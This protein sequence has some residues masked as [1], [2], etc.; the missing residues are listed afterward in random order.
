MYR[1]MLVNICTDLIKILDGQL[2][3]ELSAS[4]SSRNSLLVCDT[5]PFVIYVWSNVRYGR[6]APEI[7]Q[8]V[9]AADYDL[10]LL[11]KPDL[12]W[13]EDPLREHPDP[14][15]REAIF[16]QYIE[17]LEQSGKEYRIIAGSNR[18]EQAVSYI[19]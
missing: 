2:K 4:Q 6:V 12:P 15:D 7:I 3:S 9:N 19:N 10:I 14:T 13:Q 18:I 8:A 1:N 11:C 5:G 17:L 16:Q